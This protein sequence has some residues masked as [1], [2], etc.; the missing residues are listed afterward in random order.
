MIFFFRFSFDN[1][2]EPKVI[3]FQ[4]GTDTFSVI[5]PNTDRASS[6][7]DIVQNSGVWKLKTLRQFDYEKKASYSLEIKVVDS[8][9]KLSNTVPVRLYMFESIYQDIVVN[10]DFEFFLKSKVVG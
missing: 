10:I 1:D 3:N 9:S 4:N 8:V 7:F 5:N 6:L 2:V